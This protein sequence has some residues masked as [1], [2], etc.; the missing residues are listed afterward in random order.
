VHDLALPVL[1]EFG[2]PATVFVTSGFLDGGTM[3]N[4][5]IITA[6]QSPEGGPARHERASTR[7]L[8]LGS[9][10]DRKAPRGA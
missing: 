3:W 10:D 2:L 4:D 5:R 7:Q 1:K 9:V 6:V 8:P